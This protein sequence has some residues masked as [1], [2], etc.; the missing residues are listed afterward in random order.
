MFFQ[1]HVLR[2]VD[3]AESRAEAEQNEVDAERQAFVQFKKRVAEIEAVSGPH[4]IPTARTYRVETPNR[5]VER[6]RA[7]FRE[8]IMSVE[9]YEDVYDETLEEH[10]SGEL[11]A[12]IATGLRHHESTPFS[13]WYKSALTSAVKQAIGQRERFCEQLETEIK[14][15]KA[16]RTTLTE[17]LDT[18]NEPRIPTWYQAEFKQQLNEIARE[19]QTVIQQRPSLSQTDGHDLC[20]YLY[21]GQEWTYP[22][23]TA[24]TRFQNIVT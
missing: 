8:T 4:S 15:L 3:K 10:A 6:A 19:R 1:E 18:C 24:I 7:A 14:S 22:V 11:S 12:D 16:S 17:I 5:S 13:K 9:H 21:R 20:R 23:L 2:P